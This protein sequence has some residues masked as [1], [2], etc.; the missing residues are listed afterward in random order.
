MY[1]KKSPAVLDVIYPYK[2]VPKEQYHG[3]LLKLTAEDLAKIKLLEK[4]ILISQNKIKE[5]E[6]LRSATKNQQL[7]KSYE[8]VICHL[9]NHISDLKD[10]IRAVKVERMKIQ[11]QEFNA[12]I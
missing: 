6:D 3:P 8:R 7:L 2:K 12:I 4:D 10:K 9:L 5:K 11:R 1:V